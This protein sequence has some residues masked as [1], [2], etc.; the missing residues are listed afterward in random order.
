MSGTTTRGSALSLL[1]NRDFT[2]LLVARFCSMS[3]QQILSVAVSWQIYVLTGHALDLGLIG[4]V[5]FLPAFLLLPVTGE[6]ADRVDRRR[7]ISTCSAIGAVAAAVLFA[8]VAAGDRTLWLYYGAMLVFATS[9]SFAF[10]AQQALTPILVA[11]DDLGRA[12]A[13]GSSVNNIAMIGAPALGG[14][15]LSVRDSAGYLVALVLLAVATMTSLAIRARNRPAEQR[16]VSFAEVFA[17]VRFVV[18]RPAILGAISIDLFAVLMGDVT[19]L[20]PVY[21]KDILGV[22]ALG[23]G[24]LRSAPSI[25]AVLAALALA[26]WPLGR[27]SGRVM[28]ASLVGYGALTVVFALSHVFVVSFVALTALGTADMMSVFVRSTLVQTATPDRMRGRVSAVNAV[29][30]N[31]SNQLGQ[32]ESGVAAACFGTV[33]AAVIGGVGAILVAV[34]W[35]RLFPVL[36]AID[37]SPAG[38][39]QLAESANQTGSP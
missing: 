4:L 17:G 14:L 36:A 28:L 34:V 20:L 16:A 7:V 37:L 38:L 13:L 35:R 9:R 31:S 18:E 5:Q 33:T 10:T 12:I 8:A 2:M 3:A 23:L 27:G 30:I 26:Q 11:R 6:V 15:L 24:F 19:A 29:F 22:G 25:G 32:L 1:A 39:R 21:A